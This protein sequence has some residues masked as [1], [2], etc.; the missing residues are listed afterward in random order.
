MMMRTDETRL[1]AVVLNILYLR[2]K[3]EGLYLLSKTDIG[4]G[5]SGSV[6]NDRL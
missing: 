3:V 1:W 4:S 5:R 2:R 6:S